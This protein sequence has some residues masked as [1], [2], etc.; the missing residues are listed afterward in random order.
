MKYDRRY[1]RLFETCLR[2]YD[3]SPVS[4]TDETGIEGYI[5][6]PEKQRL[7]NMFIAGLC[8]FQTA[9]KISNHAV[10]LMVYAY[11]SQDALEQEK[12]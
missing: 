8:L 9:F 5:D 1:E 6:D 11:L 12:K 2:D 4:F 7:Y 3:A 10:D